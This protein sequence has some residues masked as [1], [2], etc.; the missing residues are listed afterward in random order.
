ME[1]ATTPPRSE[2]ITPPEASV[3]AKRR[4]GFRPA[5]RTVEATLL[6][7]LFA[8]VYFYV[9]YHVVVDLHLVNFDSLARLGHAYFVWYNDPAKLAAIGF[10][11]PPGQTL[12]LL[13]FALIAPLATSLAALPAA[14]AAFMAGTMVVINLAMRAA[15]M[16][17]FGRYPLLAAFGLNPMIVYYAANGMAEAV[18]LFFLSFGIYFLIRWGQE[19]RSHLLAFVGLGVAF[20]ALSRYE[21]V[22]F[23]VLIAGGIALIVLAGA[24]R[25]QRARVLESALV[26]YLAPIVYFGVAWL[27]FSWLI[28]G[29]PLYFLSFGA[30]TAD[31]STS[32][33]EQTVPIE[34][35]GLFSLAELLFKLNYAL[36]PLIVVIVPALLLTAVV[37]RSPMAAVLAA[38]VAANAIITLIL[39]HRS[40]DP[41]LLQLRYNMRGMPIA[42][43]GVAWLYYVWT[44]PAIRAGICVATL[45]ILLASLP[46]TWRTMQVYAYQYEESSFVRALQTGEDQEGTIAI[47]GYPIGIA[48]EKR[49][50]EYIEQ[51]PD[52]ATILTD[53]AQ[54][55]GVMLLS[56]RPDQIFDRIDRGDAIWRTALENPWDRIDY[57]LVSTNERCR[58][59]CV[60]LVRDAYPGIQSGR[61]PGME[62]V[63][64]T[65]RYVLISVADRQPGG[66]PPPDFIPGLDEQ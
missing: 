43:L 65:G 21:I 50:A 20:A 26:L 14:S 49:M 29:D 66:P 48:D 15:E 46:V 16:P 45:L 2:P 11:W 57:M 40:Q 1:A 56:G 10:V 13:P 24:P 37:R 64:S 8:G 34:Q 55:L 4:R 39:F 53:D 31:I 61:V 38:L 54:S 22:P 59:P 6:W 41:N 23:G 27:F 52:D 9:G 60:D 17:W 63:Y 42:M 51:L 33:I 3:P 44:R 62:V 58:L 18:Y 47:S 7:A 30:T 35:V 12:V 28:L 19:D 32:Q 5:G 36:L 25:R